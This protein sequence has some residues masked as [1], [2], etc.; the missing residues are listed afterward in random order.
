MFKNVKIGHKLM[1]AFI[2]VAMI[3]SISGVLGMCLLV[4]VDQSYSHALEN[5]GFA[6]GKLGRL[7]MAINENR[8]VIRDI[9]FLTE[10]EQLDKAHKQ[11]EENSLIMNELI[12][13]SRPTMVSEESKVLYKEFE[14][15]LESYR[16]VREQ[17]VELGM[18]NKQ[19]E[20]Y[21]LWINE[22][23][24][25]A[26][27]VAEIIQGLMKMNYDKGTEVS[28][29]LTY[30]G[31]III[32]VMGISIILGFINSIIFSIYIARGISRPLTEVEEA[33]V[34]MSKGDFDIKLSYESKDEIGSLSTSMRETVRYINSVLKDTSKGL[35]EISEGNFDIEPEVEYIGIFKQIEK[36]IETIVNNLSMTMRQI[37]QSSQEVSSGSEEI[38]KGATDLAQGAMEQASIIEEF[39]ASMEEISQNITQNIEEVNE[40]SEISLIAKEKANEGTVVMDKMLESMSDIS[41]SSQSISEVIQIIGNIASQTNLLALNAAIESARAGEAGRGFAVVASEIRDLANRSSDTVKEIE[42]MVK[43]S[44]RNVEEG[45]SMVGQTANVFKEIVTSVENTADIAKSL[46]KNSEQQRASISEVVQG[47]KQLSIVVETNSSTSQESAAISEELAAQAENLTELIEKFKLK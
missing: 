15:D 28:E 44:I 10:R 21:D 42:R 5:Y 7:G 17:V 47:T 27:K 1:R 46:L 35:K 26:D 40:T 31:N 37:N 22:A 24:P 8:A 16:V 9:V 6:Q 43:E 30:T 2:I 36:S 45:Q 14:S 19:E 23:S 12:E 13:E 34:K 20:A 32:L 18:Q 41:K 33:A 11:L 39:I 29:K 3:N 4:K 25:Q 38:A